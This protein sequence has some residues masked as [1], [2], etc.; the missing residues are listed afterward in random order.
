MRV[1]LTVP[2]LDRAFGGPTLL[3]EQLGRALADQGARVRIV[4]C[5][6]G[7]G[8]D[9]VGLPRLAAF[10]ATPVP[11][12][13]GP[14]IRLVR[15]AD[16]V[17]IIGYR[18]PVGTAAAAIARASHVPY[19]V[20]PAGMLRPRIR[21]L[22]LK[23]AFDRSVGRSLVNRAARVVATSRAEAAE[24]RAWGVPEHLVCVRPIGIRSPEVDGDETDMRARLG[25]P[26]VAPLVVSIGRITMKKRLTDLARALARAPGLWALVAGPPDDDG[27]LA[28]L[29]AVRDALGLEARLVVHPQGLWGREK[30]AMLSQADCFCLPS[31]SE[32]FAIAPV[33]AAAAGLPVVTTS[34]CAAIEYLPSASTRV[35]QVGDVDALAEALIEM[36]SKAARHTAVAEVPG[37][38]ARLDWGA[39]AQSQMDQYETMCGIR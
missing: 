10:H 34:A 18:D 32:N 3:A 39:I 11:A 4:G 38:L 22:R 30:R 13:L 16:V 19:V 2:S 6:P 5:G 9:V 28:E 1:C 17:H 8:P 14:L 25:L 23:G 26:S 12:V 35:V 37:L 36:S 24:M 27:A 31:A 7:T 20:E 15:A 29:L 21:S 33:E